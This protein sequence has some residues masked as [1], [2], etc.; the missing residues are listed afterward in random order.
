MVLD[1]NAAFESE[2]RLF[3]DDPN[4]GPTRSRPGRG[5]MMGDIVQSDA[6]TLELTIEA[7]ASAPIERLEIRNGLEVLETWRPFAD[8]TLGRRIRLIWEGSEYRGR[9]RQTIWD[10][11]CTLDGNSV[12]R[13]SPINM[14]NLDKKIVQT[15][16]GTLAWAAL[17]T[18]GFGGFDA[19]LAEAHSGTLRIDTPLV[20]CEVPIADIG[21]ED[22]VFN[23][24]GIGRAIRLFR[25]PDENPE[26][27]LHLTRRIRLKPDG[28]NALYVRLTQEDGHLIWSSP[29][30][31]FRD[32]PA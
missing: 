17:T 7:H 23:A 24:G 31:V 14:W 8:A 3:E 29:I 16:P 15:A 19:W 32:K 20:K 5:A 10:G 1:V 9:G 26:R 4:V 21:R 18:G 27:R 25:L 2:V 28:D 12:V 13:F 30:Y 6:D 11:G 22:L